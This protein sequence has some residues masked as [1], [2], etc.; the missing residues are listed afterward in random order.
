MSPSLWQI[1]IVIAIFAIL[2]MGP[3]KIPSLGKS[4]GQAIRGFKKGLNEDEIDV[5]ESSERLE[6]GSSQSQQKQSSKEKDKV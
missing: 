5:T 6:E 4:I 3:K 2:F 1:I